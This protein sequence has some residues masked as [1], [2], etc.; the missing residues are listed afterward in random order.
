ME[1]LTALRRHLLT[2]DAVR[3][4]V[5]SKVDKAKLHDHVDQK[6][7][8]A[9]VV[10]SNG[11]WAQPDLTQ[12]SEYP[13]ILIDFWADCS[14]DRLAD[15]IADDAVDNAMAVYRV[16]DPLLHRKRNVMWGGQGTDPG[17]QIVSCIRWSEPITQTRDESHGGVAY[18]VQLGESAVVTVQYAIHTSH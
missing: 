2:Q 1:I 8:R 15:R 11:G 13:L 12:S 18:G 7:T 4:Y 5:G 14:R 3:G 17:L 10:R 9:I 16:V 6:G